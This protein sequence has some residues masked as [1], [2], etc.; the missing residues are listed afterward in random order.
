[1]WATLAL[2]FLAYVG[3]SS[4]V[5]VRE[6]EAV[7]IT[8][9]GKP[10][11]LLDEPGLAFKLPAPVQ[12]RI[13]VD[14]RLQFLPLDPLEVVTR[15]RRNL[16]V[17]AFV[18]WRVV[19]AARFIETVRDLATAQLRLRDL[20]LAGLAAEI[21]QVSNAD[22]FGSQSPAPGLEGVF[23]RIADQANR[24]AVPEFG[25]ELVLARPSQIS[26]PAQNLRAIYQRMISEQ[27]RVARQYRAEGQEA[28]ARIQA[29][30]ERETR[31]LLARARKDSKLIEAEGE[32]KA[33]AIYARA[34]AAD[35]EYYRFSR[36]LEAYRAFLD[37]NTLLILSADDP[38]FRY[39]FTPP[40]EGG[41]P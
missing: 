35:P 21:G 39:L 30:T 6:T 29:E 19:D 10:V 23:D 8:H 33:A 7:V 12:T 5:P 20:V 9:F 13:S 3:W 37:D 31:E 27:E 22:L 16:V 15:D 26:Y 36:S 28:A 38:V 40:G 34:F 1:M 41:T 24:T 17:D 11:R 18:A 14:K 25:I 4:L 2:A 32:A